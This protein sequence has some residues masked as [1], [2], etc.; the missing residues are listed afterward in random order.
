MGIEA[1]VSSADENT[2]E[3]TQAQ[4]EAIERDMKSTCLIS[5]ILPLSTLDEDFTG[6][7]VYL[8]KLKLMKQNYRGIRRLRRDGNCFY[9]AFGFAYIEYLLNGKLIKEAGRFKKK[10]DECKDTLIANGYTQFTVEDFHEQFVGMVDR[11]TVDGGTLEELEEVF[12]DQAYSDYYVVFLRLLVSAYIQKQAGY[13]VNFIDE[14]KTINQFCETE[15]EPM[16]RE[17]DNIH[18]AALALAVELPIYVENC[19]QSGELNR[20]EFPAYSDLILDNAGE[21]SSDNHDIHSEQ[22]SNEN[23]SFINNYKQNSSSPPVTLLY[24]PG[25]YD[26]LYPNS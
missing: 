22:V 26:I 24:R 4:Q 23:D 16:A 2:D 17:S 11:F 25:H 15:V 21:T 19:Q 10:C 20:I 1:L 5:G 18:V 14:G 12:N 3:A 6:H 7:L 13:F 8:E 9:R